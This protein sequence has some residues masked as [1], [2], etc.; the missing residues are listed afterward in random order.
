MTFTSSSFSIK[1][2]RKIPDKFGGASSLNFGALN[3]SGKLIAFLDDD[4]RWEPEYLQKAVETF[5]SNDGAVYGAMMIERGKELK[6]W[7]MLLEGLNSSTIWEKFAVYNP[8]AQMSNLVM[9]KEVFEELG[10]IDVSMYPASYDKDLLI[11]LLDAGYSYSVHSDRNVIY[12][13][14]G[15]NESKPSRNFARGLKYF[16]KKHNVKNRRL[17]LRFR[18]YM[19]IYYYYFIDSESRLSRQIASVIRHFMTLNIDIIKN[20][21]YKYYNIQNINYSIKINITRQ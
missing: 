2:L 8:G 12:C 9:R 18:T 6:P 16:Y 21:I 17:I 14:H 11:R 4:D 7:K 10:G 13:H 3:S 15:E 20:S 5:R 1:Y 19:R